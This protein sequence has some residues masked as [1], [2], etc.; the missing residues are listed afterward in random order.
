MILGAMANE[1]TLWKAWR[2][3]LAALQKPPASRV[4]ARFLLQR[5]AARHV[6]R[7]NALRARSGAT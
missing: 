5:A 7:D 6:L 3:N 1:A 4:I 2:A